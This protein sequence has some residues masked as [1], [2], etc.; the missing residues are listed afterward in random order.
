MTM[1]TAAYRGIE[2]ASGRID[3]REPGSAL[4]RVARN[5]M[6]RSSKPIAMSSS[7]QADIEAGSVDP[8]AKWTNALPTTETS[9]RFMIMLDIARLRCKLRT[10][11]ID[12]NS[13]VFSRRATT[14][15]F[16]KGMSESRAGE[17]GSAAVL[18]YE[19]RLPL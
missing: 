10:E 19:P 8:E 7:P 16:P 6:T 14:D 15:R 3:S 1:T 18:M 5:L 2:L 13:L 4:E 9:V 17:F 12:R 11:E